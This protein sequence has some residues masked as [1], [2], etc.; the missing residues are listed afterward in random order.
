MTIRPIVVG[1][2]WQRLHCA[3]RHKRTLQDV[4]AHLH[5]SQ[6]GLQ[7]G[8]AEAIQHAIKYTISKFPFQQGHRKVYLKLDLKAAFQY[9]SRNAIYNKLQ[10]LSPSSL[11]FFRSAYATTSKLLYLNKTIDSSFGVRQGSHESSTFFCCGIDDFLIEL[12]TRFSHLDLNAWLFDDGNLIGD[13]ED[14]S[15]CFAFILDRFPFFGP[16]LNLFKCAVGFI[17]P[18]ASTAAVNQYHQLLRTYFPQ[19]DIPN[20]QYAHGIFPERGVEVLGTF[21]GSPLGLQQWLSQ[22]ADT[23]AVLHYRIQA[24][25]NSQ[26]QLSMLVKSLGY[27]RIMHILRTCHQL[28]LTEHYDNLTRN[29]LESIL[30]HTTSASQWSQAQLPTRFS[31]LGLLSTTVLAPIAYLSSRILTAPLFIQLT[32]S[33]IE[34]LQHELS[35]LPATEHLPSPL[36]MQLATTP[37]AAGL[38][39]MM[40]HRLYQQQHTTYTN[41]L[42]NVVDRATAISFAAPDSSRWLTAPIGALRNTLFTDSQF[43]M[44]CY[45]RLGLSMFEDNARCNACQS[46]MDPRGT[47]ALHCTSSISGFYSRYWRHNQVAQAVHSIASYARLNSRLNDGNLVNGHSADIF[48]PNFQR[49]THFVCDVTISNPLSTSNASTIARLGVDAV[50]ATAHDNKLQY[51][52]GIA[53]ATLAST[54]FQPLAF[55][56]SGTPHTSAKQFLKQLVTHHSRAS[57]FSYSAAAQFVYDYIFCTLAKANA[58]MLDAR[59]HRESPEDPP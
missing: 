55:L 36:P 37:P 50:L 40:L 52:A 46:P 10:Q 1:N 29:C 8:G 21:I 25:Q 15:A 23:T 18:P 54:T 24:L 11:P 20:H 9:I 51:P 33:T 45:I 2:T 3:V 17:T 30:R 5:P 7:R 39:H 35:L 32:G 38:Q 26:L 59:F 6:L 34:E 16:R 27:T 43:R 13:I 42:T 57:G 28:P 14:V 53:F 58:S 41:S 44:L 31:G 4:K 47:H 19:L 48:I 49:G 12:H 22:K 56:A